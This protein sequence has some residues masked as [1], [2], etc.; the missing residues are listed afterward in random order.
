MLHLHRKRQR[1]HASEFISEKNID[2]QRLWDVPGCPLGWFFFSLEP[3]H[4]PRGLHLAVDFRCHLHA[5]DSRI[6]TFRPHLF[7]KFH[8][9]SYLCLDTSQVEPAHIQ[10]S[11]AHPP[12]KPAPPLGSTSLGGS[13]NKPL[14]QVGYQRSLLPLPSL[15]QPHSQEIAKSSSFT[16]ESF[17]IHHSFSTWSLVPLKPEVSKMQI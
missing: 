7:P 9:C 2:C 4:C 15:L 10:N 1:G 16:P 12:P 5:D 8:N 13:P 14:S 3:A 11:L 6:Y 17:S